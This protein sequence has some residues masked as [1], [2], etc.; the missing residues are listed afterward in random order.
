MVEPQVLFASFNGESIFSILAQQA[1]VLEQILK[2]LENSDFEP[3][4]DDDYNELEN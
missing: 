2:W 3:D 4:F 1:K